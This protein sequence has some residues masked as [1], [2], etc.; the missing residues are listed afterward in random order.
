MRLTPGRSAVTFTRRSGISVMSESTWI[1]V[2]VRK[3]GLQTESFGETNIGAAV[4]SLGT[5]RIA[6]LVAQWRWVSWGL[7]SR[8]QSPVKSKALYLCDSKERVAAESEVAS[9][10]LSCPSITAQHRIRRGTHPL[11]TR[12]DCF[13]LPRQRMQ[14]SPLPLHRAL[15]RRMGC[16]RDMSRQSPVTH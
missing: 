9:R 15:P 2:S 10:P 11:D 13:P 16:P 6:L 7:I 8:P 5:A 12:S 4:W 3:E 1:D 14:G